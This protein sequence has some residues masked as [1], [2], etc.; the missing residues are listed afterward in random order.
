VKSTA[1]RSILHVDLAPF[2]VAVERRLDPTLRGAAVI[3]GGTTAVDGI[4]A[5]ASDEARARGVRAG[6]SLKQARVLCPN[7]AFRPGDLETYARTSEEVTDVLLRASRRVE[8]PSADEAFLDDS[9]ESPGAGTAVSKAEWVKRELQ[10][11]L[12]IEASLGLASSRLAA[13]VASGM[14]KPRGL[15]VVF[16]GYE[17]SFIAPSPIELLDELSPRDAAILRRAG[18]ESLGDLAGANIDELAHHLGRAPA[19]RFR[20]AAL[21]QGEPPI[22]RATPPETARAE[23]TIRDRRS[24]RVALIEALDGLVERAF[25]SIRPFGLGVGAITIEVRRTDETGR[26]HEVFHHVVSDSAAL[27]QI[28]RGIATP[29]LES[30]IHVRG[31]AIHLSRLAPPS[32][33]SELFPDGWQTPH[34]G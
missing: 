34:Q 22:E 32:T 15:L 24:D 18:H 20:A 27:R 1:P 30:P 25:R 21:G 33:Q 19:E 14:A 29:M 9:A 12:G 31:L 13:R 28:A 8:R 26:Q 11:R 2:L 10:H 23:V 6:Q 17:S 3:V 5:A 7:G 4:V 16:P